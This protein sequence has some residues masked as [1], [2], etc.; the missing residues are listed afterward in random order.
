MVHTRQVLRASHLGPTL[1][2]TLLATM[3]AVAVGQSWSGVALVA[4]TVLTGQLSIGWSNDW[5]DASRD[6][7]AGRLDK[8]I[9]TELVTTARVRAAAFT[10]LIV[11][12]PLSFANGVSAGA[13]H[14]G[15]VGSGWAY[16]VGLKATVL[17]WAPYAIGFGLLPAFVTL[18]LSEPV[19]PPMWAV[20]AGSLLGVG[21]HFGNVLPDIDDDLAHGVRGL[22]QR[23]DRTGAGIVALVLLITASIVVLV[24]PEGTPPA[25]SWFAGALV[26]LIAGYGGWSLRPAGSRQA[27][28][29]AAMAIALIDVVMVLTVADAMVR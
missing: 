13:A 27:V 8:P 1:L 24:A 15:L 26:A 7:A 25:T 21:A 16:N 14:L 10:A 9:A 23:L 17:S 2:V 29:R 22:P 6:M 12:V 20:L 5:L 11:T 28:F 3:L 4:V 18:G 19:W